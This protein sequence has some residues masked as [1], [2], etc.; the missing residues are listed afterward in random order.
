MHQN[1]ILISR[2][3]FSAQ[4]RFIDLFDTR[5]SL[6]AL[7]TVKVPLYIRFSPGR[8]LRIFR[9]AGCLHRGFDVGLEH[10]GGHG[11]VDSTGTGMNRRLLACLSW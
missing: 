6:L 4:A 7:G 2:G 11:F 9:A 5:R 1:H 3:F 8:H 10:H